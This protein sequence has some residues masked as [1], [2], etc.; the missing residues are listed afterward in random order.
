LISGLD[1]AVV[2]SRSLLLAFF[3]RSLLKEDP[4]RFWR[5]GRRAG[6]RIPTS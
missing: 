2:I 3:A 1:L 4:A 5:P 6:G